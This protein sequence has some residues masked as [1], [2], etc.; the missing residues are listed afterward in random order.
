MIN[1]F[2]NFGFIRDKLPVSLHEK[3]LEEY[4]SLKVPA[5]VS[6]ITEKGVPKHYFLE[7]S[8]Q[9]LYQFIEPIVKKYTDEF[10]WPI[11]KYFTNDMPILFETP[12]VNNH[13]QTE[14]FPLHS[15]NGFL[16]YAIWLQLPD[17][18]TNFN[19]HYLDTIGNIRKH[20]IK[21][22]KEDDG[23]LI[24]FP[25]TLMHGVNPFYDTE[26]TRITMSGNIS[27]SVKDKNE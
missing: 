14:F 21:L 18:E 12:W 10:G 17:V 4:H 9:E 23:S 19:F 2:Q 1:Y 15:H 20:S 16:S 8:N 3:I 13:K 25:S 5:F 26:A 27:L 24:L 11:R 22:T 6:G 7:K